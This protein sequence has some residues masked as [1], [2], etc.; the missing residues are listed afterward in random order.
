MQQ[1]DATLSLFDL[2]RQ[3]YE[4]YFHKHHLPRA[5]FIEL[6]FF[7]ALSCS[8]ERFL[9]RETG[10]KFLGGLVEVVNGKKHPNKAWGTDVEVI[11]GL[12]FE[13]KSRHWIGMVINV[14]KQTITRISCGHP[15]EQADS[16]FTHVQHFAGG[17]LGLLIIC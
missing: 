15:T 2:R 11:Y 4:T 9:E 5:A 13:K 14:K 16:V 12:T 3:N 7:N 6:W 10:R 17:Y 1:I 8:Y